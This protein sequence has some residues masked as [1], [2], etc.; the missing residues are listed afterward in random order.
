MEGGS[1]GTRTTIDELHSWDILGDQME[2][3]SG[4]N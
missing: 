2:R 3:E 1:G 4:V